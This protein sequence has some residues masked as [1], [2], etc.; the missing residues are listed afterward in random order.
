[1]GAQKDPHDA[2]AIRAFA[3]EVTA[4]REQAGLRKVELAEVLGYTPQWISQIESAKA[5][6]SEKFAEDLDTFFKT[7]GLFHRLWKLITETRRYAA[8]PPGFPEYVKHESIAST[9]YIFN[10]LVIHGLFQSPEYAREVLKSGRGEEETDALVTDRMQRQQILT[11]LHPPRIVAI[12]EEW[13][14]RRVLGNSE[15]MRSQYRRLIEEAE[16]YNISI[17]IVPI[18][19]GAY[20]GLLG[21]FTI[22]EFHTRATLVY[23]EGY[24]GGHLTDHEASVQEYRL[25]YDLIRS[26]AMSADD[27]LKL[28]KDAVEGT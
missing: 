12:F 5:V 26:A 24:T 4:W 19:A 7:N 25:S 13:A 8:L 16:R 27:S 20:G 18:T 2:P 10:P 14:I 23:T 11:R 21:A 1:M 28:L 9:M 15:V 6:P 3:T 22:L 17:Q